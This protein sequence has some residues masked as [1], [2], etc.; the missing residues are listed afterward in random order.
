MTW[1]LYT[2][3]G[4]I[5]IFAFAISGG[6]AAIRKDMD[7]LGV[8]FVAFLPAVGG[9]TLRDLCLDIPVFW[10]S[11]IWTLWV[12]LIGGLSTFFF[13]HFWNR[14]RLLR[15]MDAV[16]LAVFAP[17]GA[18]KALE[19]GHN[20]FVVVIMGVLTAIAGGLIRD[21]VCQTEAL[22]MKGEI[23]ATA[24]ILGGLSLWLLSQAG[25]GMSTALPIACSLTFAA[26]AIGIIF[27][28][29]LPK[30]KL[31]GGTST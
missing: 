18:S 11:D 30:P 3:L 8:I 25:L 7:I 1:D 17:L 14:F 12:A 23:Y 19:L 9:G 31:G 26:R 22:V 6:T 28:I 4:L 13:Y 20:G 15:W 24:A 2:V 27:Q 29:G 5:G 10:L 21:M 16:G